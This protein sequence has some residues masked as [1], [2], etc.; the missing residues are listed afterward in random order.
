[1]E[2]AKAF[3]DQDYDLGP[4][5]R[6]ITTNSGEAQTWFDRGLNWLY[7][8]NHPAAIRCFEVVIDLDP[9]CAIAHWGISFC[10]GVYYSIQTLNDEPGKYPSNADACRHARKAAALKHHASGVEQMLIDAIQVRNVEP[11]SND[12]VH[13]REL[14]GLF[15]REMEKVYVAFPGDADVA[16]LYV[17]SMMDMY[18]WRLWINGSM[19]EADSLFPGTGRIKEV[20]DLALEMHPT[21]PSLLHMFVHLMEKSPKPE[22]SLPA[23]AILRHQA[24]DASHLLHMPSH[25]DVIIGNYHDAIKTNLKAIDSNLKYMERNRMENCSLIYTCHACHVMIY[26]AMLCGDQNQAMTTAQEVRALLMTPIAEK[27]MCAGLVEPA[28]WYISLPLHVMV[29]FGMWNEILNERLPDDEDL[30]CVTLC[31]T[32]YARVLAFAALEDVESATV[33]LQLFR[34]AHS[35]IPESRTITYYVCKDILAVADAMASGEVAYRRGDFINAFNYLRHAVRLGDSL[36][37]EPWAWMQPVRHALGALL[38]EQGYVEEATNVYRE[39]LKPGHHPRNIW[40]LHG[41]VECLEIRPDLAISNELEETSQQLLEA[42]KLSGVTVMASC[43][44]RLSKC[45]QK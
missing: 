3:L 27:V 14:N 9:R 12:Q 43:Y 2:K 17:E 44:C 40:A 10:N 36:E 23:C 16:A 8:F 41:L 1:M 32:R 22:D 29:R 45:V 25:I 38:L 30:Y 28:E 6:T 11:L 35:K 21:H 15:A 4:H 42:K 34:E 13:R 24:R 18:P 5:C 37:N 39:D 33:E 19:R 7:N 20:L 26:A 31:V